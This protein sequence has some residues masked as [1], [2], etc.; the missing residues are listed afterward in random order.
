MSINEIIRKRRSIRKFK[1][2]KIE[3]NEILEMLE[4]AIF[5][6]SAGNLQPWEFVIIKNSEQKLKISECA[7]GQY[8][9][10]DAPWVI[11][12]CANQEEASSVYGKRG[13]ELYCIQDTAAAIQNILLC[14]TEKGLAACWIGAFNESAVRKTIECPQHIKPVAIIPIGIPDEKPI[15]PERKPLKDILH[16]ERF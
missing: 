15:I 2:N 7:Y 4:N 11:V 5:A 1:K 12:V 14:A 8:F 10:S 16:Y 13:H 9:I 6:P 3:E